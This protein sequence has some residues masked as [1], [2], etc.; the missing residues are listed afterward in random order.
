MERILVYEDACGG[1]G[2][3]AGGAGD[4]QKMGTGN[5]KDSKEVGKKIKVT[6]ENDKIWGW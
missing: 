2:V 3:R 4:I 6:G 5:A 1:V